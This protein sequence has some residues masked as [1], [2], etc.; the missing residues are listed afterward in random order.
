[1]ADDVSQ[2][3][4]SGSTLLKTGIDSTANDSDK[5]ITVPA[6]KT[7]EL[8][9]LHIILASTAT[10]GN[11]QIK[12]EILDDDSVVRADIHAG[13]VQAA[14]LTRHYLCGQGVYR[15]TSFVNGEMHVPIP[16]DLI[17]HPGWSFRVYDSAAVDAAADDLTVSYSVIERDL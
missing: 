11:R 5:T 15:E 2:I 4:F 1:M 6:G 10:V 3:D 12:M 7:W 17:L 9:W 8:K 14:S 13:A 16:H